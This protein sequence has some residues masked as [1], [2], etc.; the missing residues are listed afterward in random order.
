M[1]TVHCNAFT[2]T[3][4]TSK[5]LISFQLNSCSVWCVS[6]AGRH[7]DETTKQSR[8]T[9]SICGWNGEHATIFSFPGRFLP[10][11]AFVPSLSS[12]SLYDLCLQSGLFSLNKS[13]FIITLIKSTDRPTRD[14]QKQRQ[15]CV[16]GKW[17]RS[18]NNIYSPHKIRDAPE[19]RTSEGSIKEGETEIITCSDSEIYFLS[20]WRRKAPHQSKLKPYEQ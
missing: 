15:H 3:F 8:H 11:L 14:Q 12:L 6:S 2:L 17:A 4:G 9:T 10:S 20:S 18:T 1:I 5:K 16:A 7:E 19:R 13:H